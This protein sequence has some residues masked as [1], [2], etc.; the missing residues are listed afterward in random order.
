MRSTTDRKWNKLLQM[1]KR[2]GRTLLLHWLRTSPCGGRYRCLLRKIIQTQLFLLLSVTCLKIISCPI[3]RIYYR[4]SRNKSVWTTVCDRVKLSLKLV[5]VPKDKGKLPHTMPPI[6]K[7]LMDGDFPSTQYLHLT[8]PILTVF[9]TP[10]FYRKINDILK[11]SFI[12]YN[13]VVY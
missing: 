7:V 4:G 6:P 2:Q 1:S 3:L 10:K 12:L 11:C 13:S 8:L 9:D 5:M